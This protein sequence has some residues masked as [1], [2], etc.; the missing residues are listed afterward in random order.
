MMKIIALTSDYEMKPF[1]C[2]DAVLN[3]FLRDEAKLFRFLTVDA[4]LSAV[5]FYEQNGFKRLAPTQEQ[6]NT[7]AMYFDIKSVVEP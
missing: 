6:G 3:G 4:Y 2:G 5:P 1:D 7:Q